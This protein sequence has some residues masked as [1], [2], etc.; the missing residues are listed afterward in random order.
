MRTHVWVLAF[1]AGVPVLAGCFGGTDEG[2]ADAAM[3]RLFTNARIWTGDPDHPSADAM[4]IQNETILFVG[5]EAD[6]RALYPDANLTDLG[7]RRVTPGLI[8]S[9]T[10]FVRVAVGWDCD[11]ANDPFQPLYDNSQLAGIEFEISRAQIALGHYQTNQSGRTPVDTEASIADLAAAKRGLACAMKEANAMGL[12]MIVEA[13]TSSWD[14]IT[15]LQQLEQEG[16][17]TLR[18]AL[19]IT[20]AVLEQAERQ[21][22]RTGYGSDLVRVA[23]VKYYSDGWLGPRTASLFSPYNDRPG[24]QGVLFLESGEAELW[25]NRARQSGLKVATHAIGEQGVATV[26]GAYAK[27]LADEPNATDARFS[28]EHASMVMPQLVE[29]FRDTGTVASYQHSFAT[30][31]QRFLESAVGRERVAYTYAWRTLLEAGVVLAGGS[32]FP[33]E[34]LP[35]LWGLQRVV[36][37]QELDGTPSGGFVPEER[38]TVEEALRTITWNAAYNVFMEDRVGSLE[39]GKLADFVVFDRDILTIDPREIAET[40]VDQ[41]WVGGRLVHD[42]TTG[43]PCSRVAFTGLLPQKDPAVLAAIEEWLEHEAFEGTRLG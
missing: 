30:S 26:V 9:H 33:I 7:G 23:G 8:D 32:D 17:V 24:S 3:V 18:Q 39:A 42:A 35:P 19:Y 11:M 5:A 38:L 27:V 28:I 4:A 43:T 12:T 16:R 31:D 6:A 10:H 20:P 34:V 29:V 41:T 13:G 25:V 40:C 2:P 14:F 15:A 36:T 21:N 22:V 37:R 1:L